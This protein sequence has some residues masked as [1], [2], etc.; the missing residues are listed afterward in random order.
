MQKIGFIGLCI[1]GKPIAKNLIKKGYPLKVF[2]RLPD[3]F[4]EFE[5]L[6]AQIG[7]SCK[8][9]AEFADVVITMLPNSPHV[10]ETVTGD[11]GILE[12]AKQGTIEL[13]VSLPMTAAVMEMMQALKAD[14]KGDEDHCSLIKYYEKL[15]RIEVKR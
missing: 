10:K 13:G 3:S 1:M 9:T 7:T 11:N 2:D 8:D 4:P 14:G 6:G 5:T 15:A 12:G